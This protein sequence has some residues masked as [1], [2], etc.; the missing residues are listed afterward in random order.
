MKDD[1]GKPEYWRELYAEL[2]RICEKRLPT[3]VYKPEPVH[4]HRFLNPKAQAPILRKK[5]N[6]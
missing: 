6:P 4:S 2:G 1:P 3:Q 5:A